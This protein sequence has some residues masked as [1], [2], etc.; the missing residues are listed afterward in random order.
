MTKTASIIISTV[1]ELLSCSLVEEY[2]PFVVHST[3]DEIDKPKVASL[4]LLKVDT[5]DSFFEQNN[6]NTDL[7][8]LSEFQIPV[9][10][11]QS[12][13][14][15]DLCSE[16]KDL[17]ETVSQMNGLEE[18]LSDASLS[19]TSEND[20]ENM[21]GLFLKRSDAIIAEFI[22]AIEQYRKKQLRIGRKR[23][24]D[25]ITTVER[26]NDI[27]SLYIEELYRQC[28]EVEEL[29]ESNRNHLGKEQ[30]NIILSE[31]LSQ[32]TFRYYDEQK[33]CHELIGNLQP[34]FPNIA[35][36]WLFDLPGEF[37]PKWR[38]LST[39]TL[40]SGLASIVE[41]F[42]EKVKSFQCFWN[43]LD[44]IDKNVWVLEPSNPNRSFCERRVAL[45][46][47]LSIQFKIDPDNPRSVP[48]MM[49]FIGSNA[50]AHDLREKYKN[51]I[52]VEENIPIGMTQDFDQDDTLDKWSESLSFRENIE[53]C[54][55]VPF[56]T[57]ETTEKEEFIVECGVCYTHR[58]SDEN[59]EEAVIP[60]IACG[61]S[62]C[63]KNYH[64][65]CLSEWLQ[66]LPDAKQS[67]G[68]LVGTCPYCCESIAV[69]LK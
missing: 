22:S 37:E 42:I 50:D 5:L 15:N 16:E 17:I 13:D 41:E 10:D 67:F 36:T 49:R 19:V 39:G 9:F 56:P 6:N 18:R 3:K 32:V 60:S 64:E 47:A 38:R 58:I 23:K 11:K 30:E 27:E 66:S 33:R 29:L 25:Q 52:A 12:L 44:D 21:I 51:Y 45:Q 46:T 31:D 43:E 14:R 7:L 34:S 28:S 69:K 1:P 63:G 24:A 68:K 8:D 65:I 55:G 62:N 4:S 26:F 40:L 61:N 48:P 53:R 35:P 59:G 54:F 20:D 57:Q 2:G